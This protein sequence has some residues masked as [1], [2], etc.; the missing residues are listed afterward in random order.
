MHVEFGSAQGVLPYKPHRD[1]SLIS[2][3]KISIR[4][5]KMQPVNLC[6]HC[7][8]QSF[9]SQFIDAYKDPI[10]SDQLKSKEQYIQ[11]SISNCIERFEN[12]Y[13]LYAD[14]M[15]PINQALYQLKYGLRMMHKGISQLS[16]NKLDVAPRLLKFI[17]NV[18]VFDLSSIL[19]NQTYPGL[20]RD[21]HSRVRLQICSLEHIRAHH[22]RMS[23][24][25]FYTEISLCAAKN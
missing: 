2:R 19:H 11:N 9:V 17:G 18:D 10:N 22:L 23:E 3:A 13:A 20:A 24:R 14:L 25:N 1:R 4:D 12:K 6:L 5:Y 8:N 21:L 16:N 15:Q 7:G